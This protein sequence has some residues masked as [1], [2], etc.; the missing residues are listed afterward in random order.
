MFANWISYFSEGLKHV[1]TTNQK[2]GFPISNIFCLGSQRDTRIPNLF[3]KKW[4]SRHKLGILVMRY[5]EMIIFLDNLVY[6]PL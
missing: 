3:S 6:K 1:E 4:S 2:I 5:D